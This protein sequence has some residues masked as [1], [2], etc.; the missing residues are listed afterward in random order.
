MKQMPKQ[1]VVVCIIKELLMVVSLVIDVINV[2]RLEFHFVA[3][4]VENR[5]LRGEANDKKHLLK[6][7][8][9]HNEGPS[10][11]QSINSSPVF[12]SSV[13]FEAVRGFSFRRISLGRLRVRDRGDIVR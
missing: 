8:L 2:M 12:H 9:N 7:F 6:T 3:S 10:K 13:H 1:A 4:R 11:H 5:G